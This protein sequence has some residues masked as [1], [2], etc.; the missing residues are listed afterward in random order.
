[1]AFG[2]KTAWN[3]ILI[4]AG[5]AVMFMVATLEIMILDVTLF[6]LYRQGQR[7]YDYNYDENGNPRFP[8]ENMKKFQ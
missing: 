5:C 7:Y 2:I 8:R 1:M 4:A 6:E 3:A